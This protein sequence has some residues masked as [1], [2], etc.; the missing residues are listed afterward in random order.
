[1][2]RQIGPLPRPVNR[3]KS[4]RDEANPMKVDLFLQTAFVERVEI[5]HDGDIDA[6]VQQGIDQVAAM[7]PAPPVTRMCMNSRSVSRYATSQGRCP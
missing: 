3:E 4:Q 7:K 5:V 1:M 6:V 2:N